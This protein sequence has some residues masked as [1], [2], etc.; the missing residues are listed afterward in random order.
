MLLINKNNNIK[1]Q[2]DIFSAIIYG[3]SMC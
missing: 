2:D 1:N 3:K